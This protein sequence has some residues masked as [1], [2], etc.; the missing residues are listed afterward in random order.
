MSV[1]TH[2]N[3]NDLSAWLADY[4]VGGLREMTPIAAGIE[5]TNYFVTTDGGRFVL[6]LFERIPE[7]DLPFYLELM[8]FLGGASLPVPMPQRN[9][10]DRIFSP[11]N[12]KPA[13]LIERVAGEPQLAPSPAQCAAVG[14][15]LAQMHLA[16][17]A[18][19]MR[20]DNARGAAW[21]D[22]A[23]HAVMPFLN[24][25]QQALLA[26]EV[27]F[28]RD[29]EMRTAALPRGA[30]HA[31]LFRDNVLFVNENSADIA[32]IIDFG[33]AATDTLLLDLAIVANDWCIDLATGVFDDARL[34][35]LMSAYQSERPLGDDEKSHWQTLLRRA[36]LRFWLSRLYD[37]YLPREGHLVHAHDPAHFERVL[38][39]RRRAA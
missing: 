12:G 7:R 8:F 16:V 36:A 17:V 30:I 18:F 24:N 35:A 38:L 25:D 32:G 20:L 31:D 5:N 33:F 6:T 22:M 3:E 4:D 10:R 34:D 2:V 11:L 1:Y 28:Q 26:D 23:M 27:T 37:Y 14:R 13:A 19:P 39:E 29:Q 15:T 9:H 21:R